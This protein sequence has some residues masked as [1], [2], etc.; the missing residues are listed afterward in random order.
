MRRYKKINV[1]IAVFFIS[2]IVNIAVTYFFRIGTNFYA[3]IIRILAN[4]VNASA[5]IYIVLKIYQRD[6]MILENETIK[7]LIEYKEHSKRQKNFPLSATILL[8][9][10]LTMLTNIGYMCMVFYYSF[11][12]KG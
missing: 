10:S 11:F 3:D 5:G 12:M 4:I 1:W 9:Y 2:M 8:I 6:E 7:T